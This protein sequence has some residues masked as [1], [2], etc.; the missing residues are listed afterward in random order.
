MNNIV[1]YQDVPPVEAP[2]LEVSKKYNPKY[3]S[4]LLEYAYANINIDGFYGEY[5]IS[6]TTAREWEEEYPEWKEAVEMAEYRS[7]AG[8]N[9][10]LKG[11]LDIASGSEEQRDPQ[12]KRIIRG[13]VQPDIDLLQKVIFRMADLSFRMDKDSGSLRRK[14][15]DKAKRNKSNSKI[16]SSS[17]SVASG[18]AEEL[19]EKM[20]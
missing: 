2:E 19:L 11:L 6:P 9:K 15:I 13:S 12:T 17:S 16:N 7:Q 10:S 18:I 4:L 8:L 20:K 3:C 5:L 1:K 14:G